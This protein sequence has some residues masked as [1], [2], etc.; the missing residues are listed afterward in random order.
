MKQ[1]GSPAVDLPDALLQGMNGGQNTR[2]DSKKDDEQRRPDRLALG[3]GCA[4]VRA[5]LDD[6]SRKKRRARP[7]KKAVVPDPT[8]G[9]SRQ[10]T[11]VSPPR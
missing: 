5:R 11:V 2:R 4:S 7:P 9:T 6:V 1:R 8:D 3:E 10:V